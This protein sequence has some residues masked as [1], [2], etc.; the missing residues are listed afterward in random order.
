MF[1]K[2]QCYFGHL[3]LLST[4]IRAKSVIVTIYWEPTIYSIFIYVYYLILNEVALKGEFSNQLYQ[5]QP[6]RWI[7]VISTLGE[8]QIE[9][10]SHTVNSR[11]RIQT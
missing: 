8:E 10:T 9:I 7:L 1:W 11:V 3:H 5:L 4:L 6:A 2:V